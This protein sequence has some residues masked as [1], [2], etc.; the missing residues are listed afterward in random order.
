MLLVKRGL[1]LAGVFA[2]VIGC[3]PTISEDPSWIVGT[4][5]TGIPNVANTDVTRHR[6]HEDG[7]VTIESEFSCGGGLRSW[8]MRWSP[9]GDDAVL[10]E[11][12][13]GEEP[14]N[15]GF[16]RPTFSRTNDCQRPVRFQSFR[17]D[18]SPAIG[19][20]LVRGELCTQPLPPCEPPGSQCDTCM[21]VWCDD[22]EEPPTCD[23]A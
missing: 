5:S 15:F 4:F 20:D 6:F 10:V 16:N 11:A 17:D 1:V 8:T 18:G 9:S 7:T 23:G 14:Y 21:L 22:E 19:G 3:G 12:A 2:G 13:D